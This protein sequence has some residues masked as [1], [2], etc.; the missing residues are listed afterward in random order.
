M[1]IHEKR[2]LSR[3]NVRIWRLT[4]FRFWGRDERDEVREVGF[5]GFVWV[6]R[7]CAQFWWRNLCI[8]G[9][10]AASGMLERSRCR[11][12]VFCFAEFGYELIVLEYF[13]TRR[14]VTSWVQKMIEY[15]FCFAAHC[16]GFLFP[17]SCSLVAVLCCVIQRSV[18]MFFNFF[19]DHQL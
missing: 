18:F 8:G 6:C 14:L 1:E 15:R 12:T 5:E 16:R 3:R 2:G 11:D 4:P 7:C 17:S 9:G 13:V 10:F 19:P